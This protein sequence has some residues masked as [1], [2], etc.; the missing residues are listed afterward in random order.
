MQIIK[1]KILSYLDKLTELTGI[2]LRYM[3][4]GGSWSVVD[5][6]VG[7]GASLLMAMA[8][9]RLLP[10]E[11]YGTYSFVLSWA[12][13][14]STFAISGITGAITRSI[15]QGFEGDLQRSFKYKMQWG[16][17]SSLLSLGFA[18]YYFTAG[19]NILAISFGLVAV[20]LPSY[21]ASTVVS[22]YFFAKELFKHNTV[23]SIVTRSV[24]IITMV[25]TM[26][27]TDSVP[28]VLLAYFVPD[29]I[30]SFLFLWWAIK[31]YQKN[32]N[33]SPDMNIFAMHLTAMNIIGGISKRLDSIL[34]FHY[35]GAAEV[36]IYRFALIPFEK[37]QN[38]LGVSVGITAP[39]FAKRSYGEIY[40]S[41]GRK[42]I[43][44]NMLFASIAFLAFL[45]LP[46][47]FK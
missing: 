11:A 6:I 19:N 18:I 33:T 16:L 21:A 31:K 2:D 26:F 22:S 29:Q 25:G 32:R 7:N 27:L 47:A 37:I 35:I 5:F 10:K 8:F 15:A 12:G 17:I 24:A 38:V 23:I 9:T 39:R 1:N 28:I 44:F 3:V 20:F 4:K 30:I 43:W 14:F 42:L 40:Q 13:I 46:L 36:A 41:L 34:L 45:G